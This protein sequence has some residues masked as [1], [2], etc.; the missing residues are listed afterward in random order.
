MSDKSWEPG[1]LSHSLIH[2]L[3]D[4]LINNCFFHVYAQKSLFIG[5]NANAVGEKS[6]MDI[7]RWGD[8]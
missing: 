8:D 2:T 7:I 5:E 6:S 4:M 3:F 1:T